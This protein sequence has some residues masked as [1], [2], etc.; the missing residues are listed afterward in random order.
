VL[1][2]DSL[3][4]LA[5]AR[6]GVVGPKRASTRRNVVERGGTAADLVQI[7]PP[8]LF[9]ETSPSA[10]TSKGF[11]IVG[12]RVAPRASCSNG[13]AR[14]PDARSDLTRLLPPLH[15]GPLKSRR[16]F[17]W[18]V[19]TLP[20]P[21]HRSPNDKSIGLCDRGETATTPQPSHTYVSIVCQLVT[22]KSSSD[23]KMPL[24]QGADTE[25]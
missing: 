22:V 18:R 11:L 4:A 25:D 9:S 20:L 13:A 6:V 8:R 23:A 15:D 14:W 7:Q 24:S 17:G 21:A 2:V 19:A 3:R 12:M 16:E 5:V 1:H 10:R